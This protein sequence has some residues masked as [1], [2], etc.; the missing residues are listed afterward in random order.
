MIETA[1]FF[2]I[3]ILLGASGAMFITSMR[4]A[5]KLAAKDECTFWMA[6]CVDAEFETFVRETQR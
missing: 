5:T 3:G 2:L 4:S 6:P 1:A